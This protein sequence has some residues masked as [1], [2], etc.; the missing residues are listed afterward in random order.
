VAD[1]FKLVGLT[2]VGGRPPLIVLSKPLYLERMFAARVLSG[3]PPYGPAALSFPHANA[4]REGFVVEFETEAG[5]AWV[6]NF[7]ML[8]QG[9]SL[10]LTDL[11][12]SAVVVVASGTGYLVDAEEQKLIRE[13]GFNLQQLWYVDEIRALVVSN[14]LWFEAFDVHHTVWRSRRLSWDG[15]RSVSRSGMIVTGHALNPITGGWVPFQLNLSTGDV[16]GGSY[17]GPD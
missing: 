4:I 1:K 10:V 9:E 3:L 6:G 2:G 12:P 5:V 14:G 16:E 11:G 8:S 15:T 13:I 7:A 17:D